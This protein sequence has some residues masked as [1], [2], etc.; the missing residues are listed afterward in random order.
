MRFSFLISILLF[1]NSIF[2]NT[3]DSG[4]E[5][6]VAVNLK[7]VTEMPTTSYLA[8]TEGEKVNVTMIH[9]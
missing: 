2:A 1:S 6:G 8:S 4:N 3:V 9:H 7:C 5:E